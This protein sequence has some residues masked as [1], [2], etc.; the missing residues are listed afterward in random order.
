MNVASIKIGGM[1]CVRCE[2]ALYNVLSNSHGVMEVSVSYASEKAV[3]KY[4]SSIISYREICKIIKKSGYFVIGEERDKSFKNTLYMFVLSCLLTVPFGIMMFLMFFNK[5]DN[6][7][8]NGWFQ[9]IF[10]T[11]IQFV[12]GYKFYKGAFFSLKN[13]SPNMDLLVALGTSVAYLYSLYNLIR[14]IKVYYFESCAFIIT[15][16]YLGKLLEMKSKNKTNEALASL[17]KL[18]PYTVTVL[19]GNSYKEI[20]IDELKENDLFV[21]KAG[22]NIAA[23]G[24]IVNGSSNIDESM[25][26]GES[27]PKFKEKNNIVY[28]GTVNLDGVITV[29]ASKVGEHTKL[30]NIIKMVEKAQ[31]SKANVQRLADKVSAYFVPSIV[32]VAV[33]TFIF[34]YAISKNLSL[35]VS[36]T[37]A[38]LVIAC[39]CSLGLATP[40]AIIVGMGK[41]ARKGI[42]IKDAVVLEKMGN[43]KTIVL[44]KTGTITKGE[45]GVTDIDVI[46]WNEKEFKSVVSKIE[47]NSNHPL[48]RAIVRSFGKSSV[49]IELVKEFA[50]R[51]IEA[52]YAGKK[53]R[54]GNSK[55]LS[56]YIGKSYDESRT[57]VFVV[58]EDALVGVIYL[59]DVVK[60]GS[61]AAINALRHNNIEVVLASGDDRLIC[62]K[63]ARSVG[64]DKVYSDVLP[65][66]KYNIIEKVKEH[67]IVAMVG[68]GINDAP[69]LAK[70]DIGIAMGNAVDVAINSGDVIIMNND[71]MSV[72]NCLIVSRETMKKIKQNLFWAFFYN[73]IGVPLA[74]VGVISP[75]IA[76]LCM[77]LSSISVVS[78]SLVLKNK[79]IGYLRLN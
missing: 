47:E 60:E 4:D 65:E 27:V 33:L 61:G 8:H 51:G 67:G 76:G 43:L 37:V 23:D 32:L 12:V 38:V 59:E 71:M 79:K 70:A 62:E 46:G 78:N 29:K 25:L 13:S 6:I 28:G 75:I 26:T 44:D 53:V 14:G 5:H 57:K 16:V 31:S 15:L 1:H 50:G 20:K 9:F 77:S 41:A 42:L 30:S 22:E 54:I 19:K 40:T 17:L 49:E 35:S 73:C 69:A 2:K 72:Y 7:F 3:I 10:V 39:P 24:F 48:A 52:V 55:Y 64:I 36:R 74:C 34:N 58:V 68:D 11:P 56:K 63:V 18:R 45:M 66:E 21:V